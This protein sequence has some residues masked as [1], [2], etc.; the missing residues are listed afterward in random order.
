MNLDHDARNC[1]GVFFNDSNIKFS[2]VL[3]GTSQVMMVGEKCYE[4]SNSRCN[5]K[6]ISGAGTLYI[7]AA[8]NYL[9]HQNRGGNSALESRRESTSIRRTPATTFGTSN[10]VS[11]RFTRAAHCSSSGHG[12]VHFISRDLDLV[13]YR[14]LRTGRTAI[15]SASTNSHLR[16]FRD[17]DAAILG[18]QFCTCFLGL[19]PSRLPQQFNST[20]FPC[21]EPLPGMAREARQAS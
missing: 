17:E 6:Q 13:T 5:V 8:S 2:D 12:S 4:Y 11:A 15:R 3:D 7:T 1:T 20:T 19:L 18:D 9:S 21:R 16:R 14:R 10:R